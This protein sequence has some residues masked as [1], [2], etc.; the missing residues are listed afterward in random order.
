VRLQFDCAEATCP[1]AGLGDAHHRFP[2]R[3]WHA[4][5]STTLG[6][7]GATLTADV[8]GAAGSLWAVR[9]LDA[10]RG[11]DVELR[12]RVGGAGTVGAD[13]FALWFTAKGLAER[14]EPRPGFGVKHAFGHV[15]RCTRGERERERDMEGRGGTG[16]EGGGGGG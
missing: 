4:S 14:F 1:L 3:E 15:D 16:R 12:F 7:R 8:G 11:L 2:W 6:A 10:R 13:G 9:P 5:G